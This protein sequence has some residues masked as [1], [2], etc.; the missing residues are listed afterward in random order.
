MTFAG[1]SWCD[2]C[3][4]VVDVE[5]EDNITFECMFCGDKLEVSADE[6]ITEG[7]LDERH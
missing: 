1:N 6:K 5:S 4:Q 3:Q 7:D 2:R